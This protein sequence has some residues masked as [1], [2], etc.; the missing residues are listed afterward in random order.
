MKTFSEN[1]RRF[2]E[3]LLYVSQQSAED[4]TFG[5]T[6]LNKILFYS[7]FMA[8]AITG[9]PITGLEYQKIQNGPAPRRLVPLRQQLID[10]QALGIQEIPLKSGKIQHRTVNLRRPDLSVFTADQ[11]S[12]VDHVISGLSQVDANGVSELSHRMIGWKVAKMGETIPYE[13]VFLSD[14]PLT[15]ED[16]QRGLEV[17]REHDLVLE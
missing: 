12:I 4:P 15:P 7:D 5:A 2:K 16:I 6:K 3:L 8:Y 9:E 17:A 14:E 1:E 11:I 13:T 10:E